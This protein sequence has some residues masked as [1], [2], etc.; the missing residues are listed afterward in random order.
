MYLSHFALIVVGG[1]QRFFEQHLMKHFE[2][3]VYCEP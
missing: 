3:L 2:R 1:R